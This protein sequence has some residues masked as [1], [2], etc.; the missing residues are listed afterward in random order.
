MTSKIPYI[1]TSS[2]KVLTVFY[3]V[4]TKSSIR[5]QI[6]RFLQNSYTSFEWSVR[7]NVAKTSRWPVWCFKIATMRL[8]VPAYTHTFTLTLCTETQALTN[9]DY[10][11]LCPQYMMQMVN[12]GQKCDHND[13]M[14]DRR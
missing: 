6:I 1:F 12:F 9:F 8:I 11:C 4:E 2:G 3:S 10:I 13:P 14:N 5:N 7:V